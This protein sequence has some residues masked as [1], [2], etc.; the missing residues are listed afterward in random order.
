M[1]GFT[2]SCAFKLNVTLA[3]VFEAVFL[4][5]IN[6]VIQSDVDGNQWWSDCSRDDPK[7]SSKKHLVDHQ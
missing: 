3:G 1:F 4:F 5:A 6:V 2:S 7:K